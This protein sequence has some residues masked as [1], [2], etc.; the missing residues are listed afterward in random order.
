MSSQNICAGQADSPPRQVVKTALERFQWLMQV[1]ADPGLTLMAL[2]VAICLFSHLS[3]STGQC[4][5]SLKLMVEEARLSRRGVRFGINGLLAADHVGC[6]SRKGG[7]SLSTNYRLLLIPKSEKGEPPFLLNETE[8]VHHGSP[9]PT[10]RGNET[11]QKGERWCPKG[12]MVI[13]PNRKNIENRLGSKEE[14]KDLSTDEASGLAATSPTPTSS[15]QAAKPQASPQAVAP[16]NPSNPEQG[17]KPPAAASSLSSPAGPKAP[18]GQGYVP[19]GRNSGVPDEPKVTPR[20]QRESRDELLARNPDLAR[21]LGGALKCMPDCRDP[22]RRYD[23]N[24]TSRALDNHAAE[25]LRREMK[26]AS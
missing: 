26:E 3:L 11:V 2:K 23:H 13:P 8:T 14:S 16:H 6:G 5:P 20:A 4:N 19:R 25:K 12:G 15:E 24:Y 18:N 22:P 9:F 10:K 21:L 17:A 1:N 7:R